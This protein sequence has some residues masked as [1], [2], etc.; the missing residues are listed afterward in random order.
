MED[1]QMA[2]RT[3]KENDSF[4]GSSIRVYTVNTSHV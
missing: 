4:Y 2:N 3:L 1:V